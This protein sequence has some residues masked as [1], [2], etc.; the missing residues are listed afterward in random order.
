[1]SE[2]IGSHTLLARG[3]LSLRFATLQDDIIRLSLRGANG[4]SDEAI[5]YTIRNTEYGIQDTGYSHEIASLAYRLA[6]N[7][8]YS[9]EN[10]LFLSPSYPQ[11]D[12]T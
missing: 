10:P 8:N 7:D 5:P 11:F 3:I 2:V 9:S 12:L 1:M 4:V 6:R